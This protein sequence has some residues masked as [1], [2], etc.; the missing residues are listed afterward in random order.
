MIVLKEGN[1]STILFLSSSENKDSKLSIN[2]LMW[3]IPY[4]L[5]S[6]LVVGQFMK[7]NTAKSLRGLSVKTANL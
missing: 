6:S 5:S 7:S 4:V 2:E 3:S 1:S